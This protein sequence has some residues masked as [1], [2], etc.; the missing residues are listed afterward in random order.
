MIIYC[1]ILLGNKKSVLLYIDQE[2]VTEAKEIGLNLSKTCENALKNAT[3]RL[4]CSDYIRNS[5]EVTTR[6]ALQDYYSTIEEAKADVVGL[7]NISYFIDNNILPRTFE[8]QAYV[9]FMASIFRS[10]RFGAASAHGKANMLE[11]NY[12]LNHGAILF[13]EETGK[14][15]VNFARM[16]RI[17]RNLANEL[18]IIEGDGDY[19]RAQNLINDL[20]TIT[21]DTQQA[22]NRLS[23]IPVDLEFEFPM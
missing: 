13:N 11:F 20:S 6:D 9:T 4:K 18:L 10:V 23:D 8:Q 21:E 14:Y 17:I 3:K 12:L 22:L 15:S 16:N 1:G 5:D 19:E 2:I 7:Y